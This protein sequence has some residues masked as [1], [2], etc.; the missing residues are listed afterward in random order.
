MI[1]RL[2]LKAK[3]LAINLVSSLVVFCFA[4]AYWLY[5]TH[6]Q[7]LEFFQQ[8]LQTQVDMAA[9]NLGAAVLFNDTLAIEDILDSLANDNAIHQA[10]VYS[11]S[12]KVLTQRTFPRGHD[13]QDHTGPAAPMLSDANNVSAVQ[14]ITVS[15]S[16]VGRLQLSASDEEIHRELRI[17]IYY[18]VAL[19]LFVLVAATFMANLLHGLVVSPIKSLSGLAR[20]VISSHDYSLRAKPFYPDEI[21]TL[22]NDVNQMLDI[23]QQRDN[24]LERTVGERTA[25]LNAQYLSLKNQIEFTRRAENARKLTEERF[26]QLFMQAP[27]ATAMMGADLHILR[28]NAVFDRMLRLPDEEHLNLDEFIAPLSRPSFIDALRRVLKGH[29]NSVELNVEMLA[30]TGA[31][32]TAVTSMSAVRDSQEQLMYII[33][34]LL[35]VTESQ[36]L[37]RELEYQASHDALTGLPNRRELRTQLQKTINLLSQVPGSH[38][39]CL[40]DLDRFKMVND[41]CGHAAGD[42]LLRQ[43]ASMLP[44]L[45]HPQDTL[46]RLGGDEFAILLHNCDAVAAKVLTE[47]IRLAIEEFQFI[48]QSA[49]FRIGAS[50]GA[51][52]FDDPATDITELMKQVDSACY[53]AKDHGRNRVQI[54][55]MGDVNLIQREGEMRWVQT[56]QRA[57]ENDEFILFSQDIAPLQNIAPALRPR[58]EVL[59]R[60]VSA[61][62][63]ATVITP[64]S[65]FPIAERF[66]LATK[67]DTWVV[68]HL[69]DGLATRPGEQCSY[70]VNLSGATFGDDSFFQML[71]AR[72]GD[73]NMPAGTINFEIT[74]TEVIRNIGKA[75]ERIRQLNAMGCRFAL[76]DFGSG[77][78]SF[79]YLK[80]LPVDYIKIDGMFIRD[81]L[82]D[83]VDLLF[84]KAIIDIAKAMNLQTVA[85]YVTSP[86]IYN[87]V[88]ELGADFAQGYAVGEP[89]P[90]FD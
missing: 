69:I 1:R 32:I 48:W 11:T 58:K 24:L 35:D 49:L 59:L 57:L 7:G 46:A 5:V 53:S 26:E 13:P 16:P 73:A 88:V 47:K 36:R 6:Q 90:L 30:A 61:S 83:E 60:L 14:W 87:K 29:Q 38:C 72:L 8:R 43:L 66:G 76:D 27:I 65:F 3:L 4:S 64:G 51:V 18:L 28:H 67:L 68:T 80:Q 86:A 56:L 85:E 12:E 50:I 19:L 39:L 82:N 70:W 54:L 45:L 81:I 62:D 15:G 23:I 22:T 17:L 89:E 25:E 2:R 21:G 77:I 31:K 40:L 71:A 20:K 55:T 78:S 74:E 41:T 52:V 33:V 75:A 10:T 84:V 63:P 44:R 9:S 79:G 34:Q 37:A 42:E